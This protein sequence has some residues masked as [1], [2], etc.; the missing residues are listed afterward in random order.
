[1]AGLIQS[2]GRNGISRGLVHG[3]ALAGEGGFVDG[4]GALGN[5]AVYRDIFTRAYHKTVA[6][7]YL[8]DGNLGL[9]AIL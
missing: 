9:H 6:D 1:M 2:C 5:H 4:T 3:D 8:F 7:V